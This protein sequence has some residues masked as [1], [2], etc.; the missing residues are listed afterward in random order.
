[1]TNL[2]VEKF[3]DQLKSKESLRTLLTLSLRLQ[4]VLLGRFEALIIL[5]D[6]S[7]QKQR[8]MIWDNDDDDD[9]ND[10]DHCTK[11]AGLLQHYIWQSNW[12]SQVFHDSDTLSANFI[13][14]LQSHDNHHRLGKLQGA[15]DHFILHLADHCI[16]VTYLY[17]RYVTRLTGML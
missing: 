6:Q 9:N 12:R 5:L 8:Q 10:D 4:P 15:Y 2:P 11:Q 14:L 1:M 16:R 7:R 13:T 17:Y 3:L